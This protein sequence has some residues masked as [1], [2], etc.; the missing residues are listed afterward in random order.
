MRYTDALF[1]CITKE[2]DIV[3][4]NN[5]FYFEIGKNEFFKRHQGE[6]RDPIDLRVEDDNYVFDYGVSINYCLCKKIQQP[7]YVLM[8]ILSQDDVENNVLNIVGILKSSLQSEPMAISVLRAPEKS[9][10]RG[11]I[12]TKTGDHKFHIS[13]ALVKQKKLT[14]KVT[15]TRPIHL[16]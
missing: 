8:T 5:D 10:F 6:E 1:L 9:K 13:A 11:V 14:H 16:H 7:D 3:R 2:G 15:T 12:R 4:N